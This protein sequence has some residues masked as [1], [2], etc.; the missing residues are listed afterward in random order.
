[1]AVTLPHLGTYGEAVADRDWVVGIVG[2]GG[3]AQVHIPAWQAEGAQVVLYSPYDDARRIAEKVGA[4]TA[5]TLEELLDA[6]DSVDICSPTPTHREYVLAA[7]AAG[8]HVL[9][10]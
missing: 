3:I 6:V 8:R 4:R 5:E 9:C 10:E 7:A 1:M 2:A